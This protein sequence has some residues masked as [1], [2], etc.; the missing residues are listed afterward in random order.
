MLKRI[1]VL[2][3][4]GDAPGMNAAIR[5]VVRT[6]TVRGAEVFGVRQGY[7]GLL[8]GDFLPLT[9][10]DVGG[11]IERGGTM[12]GSAR[13][14][15][16]KTD[17]GRRKAL[18]GLAS[19]GIEGLIVIGGNGSQT[20]THSLCELGFPANG[21]AST[22]DNDLL[23][24][25]ITIGVDTALNV[26]LEAMDRL[27]TSAQSHRRCSIV[28][29]M[30]RDCGFLALTAGIAGGAEVIVT[31]EF[32]LTP[33]QVRERI[34]QSY[35]RG[36]Q[37]GVIVVA[38][39]AKNNA[40]RLYEALSAPH[41]S[42]PLEPRLT[43]LGHVQR[44]GDPTAADRLLATRLAADATD[45]LLSGTHGYLVGLKNGQLARTPI[46]EV[47]GRTKPLPD[48]LIRLAEVMQT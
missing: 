10:R 22:I 4:G 29:V 28:E 3:S 8:L 40:Q 41:A 7:S 46:A 12:L 1:A 42:L 16:F 25:D 39:G 26:I 15:E 44:G 6:G 37:H 48:E 33:E 21:V 14:L 27:R 2:T 31:P 5:A 34:A 45:L 47:A 19:A 36:K 32:D 20:G 24:T 38:E 30:G 18:T 11:I 35:A 43:I 17:A 13:C 9:P 23:G